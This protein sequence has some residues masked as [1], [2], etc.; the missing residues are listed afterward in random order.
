VKLEQQNDDETFRVL[1][2][3]LHRAAGQANRGEF[4]DGEP[5]LEQLIARFERARK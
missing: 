1:K 2:D 5:Y 4:V 3:R